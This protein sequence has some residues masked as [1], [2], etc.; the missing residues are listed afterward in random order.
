MNETEMLRRI[1]KKKRRNSITIR[2]GMFGLSLGQ[3]HYERL[4]KYCTKH[5]IYKSTLVR[6][7]VIEYLDRVEQKDN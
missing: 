4:D 5:S 1:V 6:N 7:L 3:E 2:Y